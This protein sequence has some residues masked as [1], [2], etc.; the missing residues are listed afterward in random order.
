MYYKIIDKRDG[1]IL[2]ELE[3]VT[4]RYHQI[5][6][7]LAAIGCPLVGDSKYG[8]SLTFNPYNHVALQ[9]YKM[10][11]VHPVLKDPMEIETG[12]ISFSDIKINR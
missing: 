8:S 1:L 4:G 2:L 5:R 6:A 3:L 11:F 9:H 10:S 12:S 7:Q